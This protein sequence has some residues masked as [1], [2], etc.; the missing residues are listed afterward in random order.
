MMMEID[1]IRL[2]SDQIVQSSALSSSSR[3][4]SRLSPQ[5]P[6][7]PPQL[8]VLEKQK[9]STQTKQL[10]LIQANQLVETSRSSAFGSNVPVV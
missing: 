9:K 3:H 8:S 2:D 1:V 6:T 4:H 7:L 5:A 10:Y